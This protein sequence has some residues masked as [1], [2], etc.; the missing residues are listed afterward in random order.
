MKPDLERI[1]RI[2]VWLFPIV[3]RL[4]PIFITVFPLFERFFLFFVS[5]FLERTLQGWKTEGLIDNYG[6]RT[7]KIAKRH[8]KI[9]IYVVLTSEQ[10]KTIL[11]DLITKVLRR[12]KM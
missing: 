12:L 7:E 2:F 1:I 11:N 4:T 3:K 5:Y 10:T 6:T 9:Q 8:Y